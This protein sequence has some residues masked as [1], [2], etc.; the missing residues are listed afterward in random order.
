[1]ESEAG[2]PAAAIRDERRDGREVIRVARVTQSEQDGDRDDDDEGG[3]VGEV[4]EP[5][6][7]S[8]HQM[9]TFGRARATIAAPAR[10]IARASPTLNASTSAMPNATRC[11]EIAPRSTTSADGHGSRPPEM[12]TASRPRR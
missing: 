8:E 10:T 12:P 9:L 11:S 7:E 3:A 2:C 5:V 4:D 6:V 1:R